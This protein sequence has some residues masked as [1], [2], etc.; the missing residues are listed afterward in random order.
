MMMLTFIKQHLRNIWSSIHDNLSNTEAKKR[1]K[2]YVYK[3]SA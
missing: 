3:N 2:R 1:K